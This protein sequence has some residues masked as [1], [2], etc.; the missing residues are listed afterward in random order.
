MKQR[1]VREYKKHETNNGNVFIAGNRMKIPK[2]QHGSMICV[3][4]FW[5]EISTQVLNFFVNW[6][7][8]FN[9]S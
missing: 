7:K 6:K 9:N 3:K 8:N 5:H 2:A 1:R 4:L